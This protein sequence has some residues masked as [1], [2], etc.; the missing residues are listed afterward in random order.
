MR[1]LIMGADEIDEYIEHMEDEVKDI[2]LRAAKT[3]WASRGSLQYEDALN[4]SFD[5]R[6]IFAKLS[7]EHLKTTEKSGLPYF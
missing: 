1:L 2:K 7:E 5:E 6:E 3:A 4:L